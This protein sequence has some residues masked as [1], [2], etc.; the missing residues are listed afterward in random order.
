MYL[1]IYIP[2]HWHLIELVRDPLSWP[3]TF[4]LPIASEYHDSR[5]D[6]SLISVRRVFTDICSHYKTSV[7]IRFNLH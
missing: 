7:S 1:A 5:D 2:F 3:D 4:P 6:L